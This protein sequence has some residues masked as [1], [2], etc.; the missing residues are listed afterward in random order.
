ML[1]LVESGRNVADVAG[2][3]AISEQSISVWRSVWRREDRL[4]KRMI[5][6]LTRVEGADLTAATKRTSELQTKLAVTPRAPECWS[7]ERR[8]RPGRPKRRSRQSR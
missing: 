5:R 3:P 8:R 6:G 7:C 4:D 2:D 1:G